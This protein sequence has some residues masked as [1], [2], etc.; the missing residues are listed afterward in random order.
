MDRETLGAVV[1]LSACAA[2][3]IALLLVSWFGGD[4][5]FAPSQSSRS[6]LSLCRLLFWFRSTSVGYLGAEGWVGQRQLRRAFPSSCSAL[7]LVLPAL[8]ASLS[9]CSGRSRHSGGAACAHSSLLVHCCTVYRCYEAKPASNAMCP[10]N[11]RW[12]GP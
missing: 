8:A 3:A 12:R 5:W 9:R 7:L 11:N 6:S 2:V 10:A 1:K 4:S